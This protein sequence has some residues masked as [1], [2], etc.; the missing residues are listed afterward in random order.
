MKAKINKLKNSCKKLTKNMMKRSMKIN[1]M[2]CLKDK[3][4]R[5]KNT[6]K[7]MNILKV[8]EILKKKG[9]I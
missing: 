4:V 9:L 3:S 1:R 7:T 2:R 6:L 8:E 5:M